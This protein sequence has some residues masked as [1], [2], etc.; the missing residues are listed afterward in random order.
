MWFDFHDFMKKQYPKRLA[1]GVSPPPR[2]PA[3]AFKVS[4][5]LQNPNMPISIPNM[6]SLFPY[7]HKC[8]PPILYPQEPCS[9]PGTIPQTHLTSS[10]LSSWPHVMETRALCNSTGS[11]MSPPSLPTKISPVPEGHLNDLP[12]MGLSLFSTQKW[13]FIL[14]FIHIYVI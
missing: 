6:T 10:L 2:Y 8:F 14:A 1:S 4:S 11:G 7:K 3:H 5:W 13:Q 9:L 12:S